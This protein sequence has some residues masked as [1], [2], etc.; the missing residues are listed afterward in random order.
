MYF[1]LASVNV[2]VG[3]I[4]E[5][6][7]QVGLTG[8]TGGKTGKIDTPHLHLGTKVWA[9][10]GKMIYDNPCNWTDC[11]SFAPESSLYQGPKNATWQRAK[12]KFLAKAGIN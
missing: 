12:K 8:E 5:S 10:G 7:K 3:D 11:S 2:Q 4:V 6:G 1:H 9:V